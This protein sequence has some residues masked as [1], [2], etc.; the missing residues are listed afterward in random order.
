[1]IL[2]TILAFAPGL[3]WLRFFYRKDQLEPEPKQLIFR[4]FVVGLLIFFPAAILERPFAQY[5]LALVLV[6]APVVEESCKFLAVRQLVY[7]NRE[8]D[9]PMDG[10]V[11]AASVALGFASLENL[12]YLMEALQSGVFVSTYVLRAILSVP[13]HVLFSSLWGYTLGLA[14]FAPAKFRN[15]IILQGFI[16][17]IVVHGIFN[18]F[19]TISAIFAVGMLG[20][21][22]ILW[23]MVNQRIRRAFRIAQHTAARQQQSLVPEEG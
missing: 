3:F 14:K 13:G 11:Y 22:F 7:K 21:V 12:G 1:V 23:K 20:F 5:H 19:A 18:F 8:F 10:I 4:M 16:S 15:K 9:E 6:V 17:S 2:L